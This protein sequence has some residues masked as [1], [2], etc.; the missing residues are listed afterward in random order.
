MKTLTLFGFIT[1]TY[2]YSIPPRSIDRKH[3]N[4]N[5][6]GSSL[7][8]HYNSPERKEQRRITVY[9]GIEPV[10]STTKFHQLVSRLWQLFFGMYACDATHQFLFSN[11][12]ELHN[13]L[14]PHAQP[15]ILPI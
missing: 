3:N 12:I 7:W 15:C 5:N 10:G 8:I 1:A 4:S 2:K 11:Y 14:L 9:I 13:K 6:C